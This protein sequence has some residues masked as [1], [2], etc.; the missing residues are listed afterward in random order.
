M[1]MAFGLLGLGML[2]FAGPAKATTIVQDLT[3]NQPLHENV[4]FSPSGYDFNPAL[5][6]LDSV[7][8]VLEGSGS[9]S[10]Y[11]PSPVPGNVT[12]GVEKADIGLP[13]L[14]DST[15][16]SS[17][18]LTV[19]DRGTT[20]TG[21]VGVNFLSVSLDSID[22]ISSD[23]N[24]IPD[25]VQGG[26]AVFPAPDTGWGAYVED[27]SFIGEIT[28]TYTYNVPEPSVLAVLGAGLIGLT[29]AIRRRVA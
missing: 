8:A 24:L 12:F 27:L 17:V 19:S 23:P 29:F 2:A 14:E 20:L 3:I 13:L 25:L 9:V 11:A 15:E 22:F 21:Y 16:S 18:Q 5:G 1:R 6:T 28:L 10:I 26:V 7:T 4:G